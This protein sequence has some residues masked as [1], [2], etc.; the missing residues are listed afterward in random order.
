MQRQA[1]VAEMMP[2]L[3]SLKINHPSH[4]QGFNSVQILYQKNLDNLTRTPH[5]IKGKK[6]TNLLP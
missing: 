2:D 6:L 1:G 3:A 5:K 4:I